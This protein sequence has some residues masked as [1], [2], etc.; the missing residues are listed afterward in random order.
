MGIKKIIGLIICI[1]AASSLFLPAL[2]V[3]SLSYTIWHDMEGY[4]VEAWIILVLS[5]AGIVFSAIGKFDYYQADMFAIFVLSTAFIIEIART[6]GGNLIS[7][8]PILL[9][10]SSLFG[11]LLREVD[12]SL[13]KPREKTKPRDG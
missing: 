11:V 13:S 10:A 8:G 12:I 5:L 7:I 6:G 1:A 4:F 9:T 2:T 3:G